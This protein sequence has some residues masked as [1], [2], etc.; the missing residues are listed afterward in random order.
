M[1][2]PIIPD[3]FNSLNDGNHALAE[4]R[5]EFEL[6]SDARG[7][8]QCID[9][10]RE[11]VREILSNGRDEVKQCVQTSVDQV[12]ELRAK[13][14]QSVAAIKEEVQAIKDVVAGCKESGETVRCILQNVSTLKKIPL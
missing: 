7:V 11:D 9:Q 5:K 4:L 10:L 12:V 14:E 3:L 2:E 13:L 6:D 8:G 1:F